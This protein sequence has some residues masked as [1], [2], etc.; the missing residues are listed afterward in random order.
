MTKQE[1]EKIVRE[2]DEIAGEIP[3]WIEY[4]ERN[5]PSIEQYREVSVPAWRAYYEMIG[6]AK[7]R[8]REEE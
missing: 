3:K 2:T 4:G 6:S 7:A 8:I 5:H 1:A